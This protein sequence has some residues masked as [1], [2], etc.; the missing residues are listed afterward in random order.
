MNFTNLNICLTTTVFYVQTIINDILFDDVITIEYSDFKYSLYNILFSLSYCAIITKVCYNHCHIIWHCLT[1]IFMYGNKYLKL[2]LQIYFSFKFLYKQLMK[3]TIWN[4]MCIKYN[5]RNALKPFITLSS[6]LNIFENTSTIIISL[7]KHKLTTI[8]WIHIGCFL[9]IVLI[10]MNFKINETKINNTPFFDLLSKKVIIAILFS[11]TC[12]L[13]Y[14]CDNLNDKI[15]YISIGS[16]FLLQFCVSFSASKNN[17]KFILVLFP[18]FLSLTKCLTKSKI[19][20]NSVTNNIQLP[21]IYILCLQYNTNGIIYLL[22]ICCIIIP[23]VIQY[24]SFTN[25]Y[26]NFCI[27]LLSPLLYY[28]YN[29]LNLNIKKEIQRD[30]E[31]SIKNNIDIILNE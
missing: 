19:M 20:L 4:G 29:I 1:I 25:E 23:T 17:I 7:I 8:T 15:T 6:I 24:L 22:N 13:L 14:Y 16:L 11:F 31:N 18:I 21:I 27:L 9:N 3:I 28:I 26:I 30:E 5:Y 2:N 12:N 10:F